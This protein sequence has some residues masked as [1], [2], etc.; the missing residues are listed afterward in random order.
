MSETTE[1]EDFA[2]RVRHKAAEIMSAAVKE[3]HRLA[4]EL[5]AEMY[6]EAT[7]IVQQQQIAQEA[8]SESRHDLTA[9]RRM[10]PPE[11]MFDSKGSD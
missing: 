2:E 10:I 5:A 8:A 9:L 4:L 1:L 3:R 11:E 7:G 6:T